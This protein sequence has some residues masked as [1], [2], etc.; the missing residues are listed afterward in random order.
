[1]KTVFQADDYEHIEE[2]SSTPSASSCCSNQR[3]WSWAW[4]LCQAARIQVLPSNTNINTTDNNGHRLTVWLCTP[5]NNRSP[6]HLQHHRRV[7]VALLYARCSSGAVA[8]T[9]SVGSCRPAS[10]VATSPVARLGCDTPSSALFSPGLR[11][12]R[13]RS[14]CYARGFN[15]EYSSFLVLSEAQN[16]HVQL[17]N[18]CHF[19]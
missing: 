19:C 12:A 16:T 2:T 7:A 15:F 14:R 9:D 8:G 11:G 5:I 4:P 3:P 18:K 17:P 6:K 10:A 1:M 13:R